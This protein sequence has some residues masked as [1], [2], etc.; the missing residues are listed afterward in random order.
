MEVG[1]S[2][3]RCRLINVK[4]AELGIFILKILGTWGFLTMSLSI[5]CVWEVKV[6]G[7]SKNQPW[8]G[9]EVD[10]CRK[11]GFLFQISRFL[12]RYPTIRCCQDEDLFWRSGDVITRKKDN[13]GEQKVSANW[14]HTNAW[15][16]SAHIYT[17]G[18]RPCIYKDTRT[19]IYI[20]IYTMETLKS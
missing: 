3:I 17:V 16:S 1:F 4:A 9:F 20:Y 10:I 5:K 8:H 6:F 14:R 12:I 15:V 2:W 7:G 11:S 13:S 19:Y 18:M